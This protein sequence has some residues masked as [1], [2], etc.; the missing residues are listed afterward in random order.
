MRYTIALLTILLGASCTSNHFVTG[1]YDK[2]SQS[3]QTIAILPCQVVYTGAMEEIEAEDLEQIREAESKLF[4]E[5]MY[6]ELL[7][8]SSLDKKPIT[9]QFQP[10]EETYLLLKRNE[11]DA[12][13]IQE[14][15]S[16]EIAALLGVDAIVK[17]RV[18]KVRFMSDLASMGIKYGKDLLKLI[19]LKA[20]AKSTSISNKTN[21]IS[22]TSNIVD[23]TSGIPV[24]SYVND[25]EATNFKKQTSEVVGQVNRD[26]AKNFP[27]REKR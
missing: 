3:H 23:G 16:K 19:S 13:S 10:V 12:S 25:N 1:S 7:R 26:I 4:T 8:E 6:R 22:V 2:A 20:W 14:M 15:T 9:V 21:E 11:V 17:T 5:S 18:E 27:Y 24:W